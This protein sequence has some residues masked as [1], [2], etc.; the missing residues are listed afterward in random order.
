[1][2][3]LQPAGAEAAAFYRWL[4]TPAARAIFVRHGLAL[5]GEH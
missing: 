1:M 5:P 3:L 4:Q 2:A